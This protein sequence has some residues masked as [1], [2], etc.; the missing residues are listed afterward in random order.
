MSQFLNYN[1]QSSL[2]PLNAS[3]KSDYFLYLHLAISI[4]KQSFNSQ[5]QQKAM[6]LPMDMTNDIIYENIDIEHIANR[7]K[8]SVRRQIIKNM[9]SNMC[10]CFLRLFVH[11]FIIII[12]YC[13]VFFCTFLLDNP[14]RSKM[15]NFIYVVLMYVIIRISVFCWDKIDS[16]VT[17][18]NSI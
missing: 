8:E 5:H 15:I 7:V 16:M 2:N 6:M 17:A 14:N 4:K 18:Q 1:K 13:C 9:L 11:I 10:R 12:A 3:I